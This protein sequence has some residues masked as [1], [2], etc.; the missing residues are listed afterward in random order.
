MSTQKKS[1]DPKPRF[2]RHIHVQ[3]ELEMWKRLYTATTL[4]RFMTLFLLLVVPMIWFWLG[5]QLAWTSVMLERQ[6]QP[7]AWTIPSSIIRENEVVATSTPTELA[8]TTERILREYRDDEVGIAFAHPVE[9]G[10]VTTSDELGDCPREYDADRCVLR[11]YGFVVPATGETSFFMVA[12]TNGMAEYPAPRG[13]FW[14]DLA[15]DIE[16]GYRDVC[17]QDSACVLVPSQAGRIFAHWE[18]Q[19]GA[20]YEETYQLYNHNSQFSRIVLTADELVGSVIDVRDE[21][22][23]VLQSLHLN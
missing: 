21:F 22:E 9:W 4:S 8:T 23:A 14:G 15:R 5:W 16:P 3:S 11:R 10:V 19:P 13:A 6:A 1:S 12:M 20:A 2:E 18:G 17:D 7:I